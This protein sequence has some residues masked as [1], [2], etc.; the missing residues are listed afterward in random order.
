MIGAIAKQLFAAKVQNIVGD[1][2]M[3]ELDTS[4]IHEI[5]GVFGFSNVD[6]EL[7][8]LYLGAFKNSAS[9]VGRS[10]VDYVTGGG[11]QETFTGLVN[12]NSQPPEVGDR[13]TVARCEICQGLHFLQEE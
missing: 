4:H 5:L 8:S 10:V 7:A 11:L 13:T 6:D 12:G 3:S 2:A 1:L 9:A